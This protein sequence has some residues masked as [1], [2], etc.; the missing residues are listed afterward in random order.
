MFLALIVSAFADSITLDTGATIE[1]DL[2]HYEFGG[3]CQ[4]SVTEPVLS[5]VKAGLVPPVN[6]TT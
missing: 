2:A 4:I 1:G 3:D 5:L 6:I